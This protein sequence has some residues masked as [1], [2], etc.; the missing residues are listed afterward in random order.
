MSDVMLRYTRFFWSIWSNTANV[1]KQPIHMEMMRADP[2][3]VSY[4]II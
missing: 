2:K 1:L 4:S 3:D